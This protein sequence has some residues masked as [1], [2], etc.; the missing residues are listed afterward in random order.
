[1][2]QKK[3]TANTNHFQ[4]HNILLYFGNRE[5]VGDELFIF[6][7][8]F[9]FAGGDMGRDV[10]RA[11]QV[12]GTVPR[13]RVVESRHDVGGEEVAAAWRSELFAFFDEATDLGVAQE[14]LFYL[15][16]EIQSEFKGLRLGLGLDL[17]QGDYPQPKWAL[18]F[19]RS[20]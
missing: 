17:P 16:P 4:P 14:L 9:K 6:L 15:N 8:M 13:G 20:G 12:H 19:G 11:N 5:E 3:K 10:V 2:P 7:V 18:E 1:M